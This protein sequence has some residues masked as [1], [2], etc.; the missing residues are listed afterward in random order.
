[1]QAACRLRTVDVFQVAGTNCDQSSQ[2][3]TGDQPWNLSFYAALA[4]AKLARI[5]SIPGNPV[6]AAATADSCLLMPC[7][8]QLFEGVVSQLITDMAKTHWGVRVQRGN[9]SEQVPQVIHRCRQDLVPSPASTQSTG[10]SPFTIDHHQP[11]LL[12]RAHQGNRLMVTG[13]RTV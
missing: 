13:G 8:H 3:S 7:V 12:D 9:D 5:S 6:I 1:M 11:G 2:T 4:I 10:L